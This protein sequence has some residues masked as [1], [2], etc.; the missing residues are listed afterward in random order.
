MAQATPTTNRSGR[1]AAAILLAIAIG[2]GAAATQIDYAFSSDPLGPKAVPL[3]LSGLLALFAL[4]YWFRPGGAEAFP[5][6]PLLLRSLGFIVTCFV[7]V[8]LL[9]LVGFLPAM[10]VLIGVTA[11]LFG[12]TLPG[13]A[14][15][16]VVQSAFWFAC[17]KYALGTYLPMGTLF[18]GG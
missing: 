16:G 8:A 9:D 10:T 15:I 5:Q 2:L 13:A 1:I 14:F 6:G 17:F 3:I 18:S 7:T 4:Y 11:Y 12:A